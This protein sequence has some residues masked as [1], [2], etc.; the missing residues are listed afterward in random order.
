MNIEDVKNISNSKGVPNPSMTDAEWQEYFN[1]MKLSI[2]QS[3]DKRMKASPSPIVVN[4]YTS[5]AASQFTYCGETQW[6]KY[7]KYINSVLSAIRKGKYDYCY[8]VYQIADL[9]KYEHDNLKTL[10]M[11][12]HGCIRVWLNA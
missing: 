8:F 1:I 10:W 9:L 7:R 2:K 11:P 4:H 6:A 5:E 3:K 12:E